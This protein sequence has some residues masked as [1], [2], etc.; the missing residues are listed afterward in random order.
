MRDSNYYYALA[1]EAERE[2]KKE[3]IEKRKKDY[4]DNKQLI[5]DIL[6]ILDSSVGYMFHCSIEDGNA[7]DKSL[8]RD[9]LRAIKIGTKEEKVVLKRFMKSI[10]EFEYDSCCPN[11]RCDIF[12]L[13]HYQEV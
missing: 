1:E 7:D 9:Y 10:L 6:F 2:E 12:N 8:K 4:K 13:R 11:R 3:K 5:D